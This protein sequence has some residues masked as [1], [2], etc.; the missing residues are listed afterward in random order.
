GWR[1][2]TTQSVLRRAGSCRP[3][4]RGHGLDLGRGVFV[5]G[6]GF[7]FVHAAAGEASQAEGRGFGPR[8]PLH[9]KPPATGGFRFQG[10]ALSARDP[11]AGESG[12]GCAPAG[13]R[14][15]SSVGAAVARRPVGRARVRAVFRTDCGW[16]V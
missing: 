2:P 4:L 12:A 6:T 13:A 10:R 5:E 14:E 7:A 3:P 9:T 16:S 11:P 1:T 8:R 15:G